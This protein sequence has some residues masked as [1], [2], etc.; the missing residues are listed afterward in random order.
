VFRDLL[1]QVYRADFFFGNER[2]RLP[3]S[4]RCLRVFGLMVSRRQSVAAVTCCRLSVSLPHERWEFPDVPTCCFPFKGDALHRLNVA[5]RSVPK[6]CRRASVWRAVEQFRDGC[7]T[8][9]DWQCDCGRFTWHAG[10]A[11][12]L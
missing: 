9:H 12:E 5:S 8:V 7:G 11:H 1:L 2:E 4:G 6:C 10:T 3:V